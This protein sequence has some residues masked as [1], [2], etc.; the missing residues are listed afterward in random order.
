EQVDD[1]DR[2]RE[3]PERDRD[4]RAGLAQVPPAA[5]PEGDEP[6][7]ERGG[8]AAR[9]TS[10]HRDARAPLREADVHEAVVEMRPVGRGDRLPVLEPLR[11]HDA[12]GEYRDVDDES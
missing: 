7:R 8:R 3:G 4:D 6:R 2:E 1:V 12:S 11:D 9:A 10:P 5:L